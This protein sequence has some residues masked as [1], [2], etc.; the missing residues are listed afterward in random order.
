MVV[1]INL[2]LLIHLS[3]VSA[4]GAGRKEI[5]L[6]HFFGFNL[7]IGIM[8]DTLPYMRFFSLSSSPSVTDQLLWHKMQALLKG[9]HEK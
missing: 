7:L 1:F 6:V 2:L 9:L 4:P 5:T 8:Q 3:S